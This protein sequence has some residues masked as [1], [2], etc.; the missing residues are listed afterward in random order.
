MRIPATA[1]QIREPVNQTIATSF[2]HDN[3]T[4]AALESGEIVGSVEASAKFSLAGGQISPLAEPRP[5]GSGF[6]VRSLSVAALTCGSLIIGSGE[7]SSVGS[8]VCSARILPGA[9]SS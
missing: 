3:G 2:S 5:T 9:G 6:A 1:N 4:A 8:G 7:R